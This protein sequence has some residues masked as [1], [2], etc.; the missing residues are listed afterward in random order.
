MNTKINILDNELINKISA[1]EVVERPASAIKELIE[2][3]IDASSDSIEVEVQ[4]A[5]QTLIRVADNGRG[6]TPEDAEL[7]CMRHATSKIGSIEDLE[8]IGTLGFRGEAL[9]S[10]AAV[11]QMDLMTSTGDGPSGVYLYLEN[12]QVL[13]SRPVGRSEGTT[14]EVRNLFYN[15]PARKKF[16]K[17]E[18]TEL[19]EIV[20]TVGRF[21]V[22]YPGIEFKL[23]HGDRVLLHATRGMDVIGRIRLVMGAD[24][25][26][27]MTEVSGTFLGYSINGFLSRPA[28]TRKDRKAQMFFI[29]DRFVRSKVLSDGVFEGYRSLLERG[30]YPAFVLF[31]T[32]DPE[33]VDVNVHPTKLQV[34]FDNDREVKAAVAAIVKNGFDS[35]KSDPMKYVPV[36]Q[37]SGT[38]VILDDTPPA[39]TDTQETQ[40]EFTYSSDGIT[41]GSPAAT[42]SAEEGIRQVIAQESAEGYYQLGGCYIVEISPDRIT[43]T[44]QHA[45]HERILYEFFSKAAGKG[46][47]EVQ[48][49]LFPVRIDLSVQE[50]VS[51]EKAL[52]SFQALGFEIE[53][54]GDNSFLVQAAPS[55]L[56]DRD[57]KSVVCDILSDL[58]PLDLARVNMTEELVKLT[59]CRAAIK[60]GDPLTSEEMGSLLAQLKQCDL[61]FTCP[62]GRPTVIE[63]T[64]EELEKRFR[65]K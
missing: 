52:E 53:I 9:A 36:V 33:H 35:L 46:P 43:I 45:A 58:A 48:N 18:A 37:E 7:A 32:T 3:S 1:G 26:E 19:G 17:K 28:M 24:I 40:P 49:L 62:H 6:M 23:V 25:A 47:V 10:I 54:F 51:M 41:A 22:S 31:M 29:N 34:K 4:S 21:M 38:A 44:D 27:S 15:V 16:L 63:V 64:I 39:L 61:P 50:S 42:V 60:A 56:K 65:R 59:A 20:S 14:V 2:N 55:V 8:K 57:I 30:R 11:A 5:G 13:R 12:G